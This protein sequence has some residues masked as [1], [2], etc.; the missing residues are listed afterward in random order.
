MPDEKQD[1][2]K[3]EN[4]EEKGAESFEDQINDLFDTL[5]LKSTSE[6]DPEEKQESKEKSEEDSKDGKE[7]DDKSDEDGKIEKGELS[8]EEEES[9]V[10]GVEE[11]KE[12]EKEEGEETKEIASIEDERDSLLEQ[13]KKLL[14]RLEATPIPVV[15]PAEPT[16]IVPVVPVVPVVPEIKSFL[17]E[18]DIDEVVSDPMKLEALLTRVAEHAKTTTVEH[19]LRSMPNMIVTQIQQQTLIKN[20]VDDFYDANEDLKI[21]KKTV[22]IMANEV[23][24]EDPTMTL[25]K[26][27]KEAGERTRKALGLKEFVK[28]KETKRKARRPALKQ[29]IK[30][31]SRDTEPALSETQK[32]IIDTFEL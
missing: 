30:R 6:E 23:A 17:G 10:K 26:V 9:K 1:P 21:A 29:T 19:V 28:Q 25:D 20:A 5:D 3:D 8:E 12:E 32:D 15:K 24:A 2:R 14:E 27:F 18:E 4:E 31:G 13:N 22:G 7:E 11:E 16:P